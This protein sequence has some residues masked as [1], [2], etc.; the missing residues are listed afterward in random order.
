MR[1]LVAG[2]SIWTGYDKQVD[3]LLFYAIFIVIGI[4]FLCVSYVRNRK[5]LGASSVGGSDSGSAAF[6]EKHGILKSAVNVV[7]LIMPFY[8]FYLYRFMYKYKGD[9]IQLF[10]SGLWKAACF[11]ACAVL[12]IRQA[13]LIFVKK[14]KGITLPTLLMIA[15][16]GTMHTPEGLLSVDFFH[17]GETALPMHQLSFGKLP[18]LGFDPIHGL[19]DY[20]YS[21][22]NSELFGGSYF[23]QSPA[24]VIGDMLIA[25]FIAFVI[26]LLYRDGRRFERERS[27]LFIWLFLPFITSHMGMRYLFFIVGFFILCS[28]WA[29]KDE[30][31]FVFSYAILCV[32]AITWNVSIGGAFALAFLPGALLRIF[33]GILPSLKDIKNWGKKTIIYRVIFG[34]ASVF[35]VMCFIPV[36]ILILRFLKENTGQTLYVNGNPIF[37]ANFKLLATF[38]VLLPIAYIFIDEIRAYKWERFCAVIIS[39]IVLVNYACVRYD[40]GERLLVLAVF[41]AFFA[42]ITDKNNLL[43]KWSAGEIPAA[44]LKICCILLTIYFTRSL[45]PFVRPGMLPEV[46]PDTVTFSDGV[47][48]E[49]QEDEVV[50]LSGASV[51]MGQ[52][53][54]GFIRGTTLLSLQNIQSV[55]Q[56]ESFDVRSQSPVILDLSNRISDLVIFDIENITPYSSAYNMSTTDMQKRALKYIKERE[57][58]IIFVS[59][60]ICFD[61]APLSLRSFY[62]YTRIMKMGYKPYEYGDVVYLKKTEPLFTEAVDGSRKF[63][64]L[65]HKEQ[66]GYLPAIWGEAWENMSAEERADFEDEVIVLSAES[67]TDGDSPQLSRERDN[68]GLSPLSRTYTFHSDIDGEEHRFVFNLKD[69][70]STYIIPVGSSPFYSAD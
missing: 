39:M 48:D 28:E 46:I 43:W 18:Y 7:S 52:L 27:A 24:S 55:L 47:S 50:Y 49:E 5:R 10:Y 38:G 11:L 26:G 68:Q 16:Y 32:L 14:S 31:N 44:L 25:V 17:N 53:G 9:R 37:G 12:L 23:A 63:G 65:M 21:C 15:S 33:K 45:L 54:T 34:L 1:D 29:R 6:W 41:F 66:L 61:E 20:Y 64:L 40:E 35:S 36:F 4:A 8:C 19:C 58:E 22:I 60:Y 42:L 2:G 3:I 30:Y 13:Y 56:G 62:L 59:P 70:A 69:G 51:G 57:P 67:V